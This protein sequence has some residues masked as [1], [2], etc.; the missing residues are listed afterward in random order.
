MKKH[1]FECLPPVLEPDILW[2]HHPKYPLWVSNNG[3]IY[4][5]VEDPGYLTRN[6]YWISGRKE[7]FVYEACFNVVLKKGT[8]I[9]QKDGNPYNLH[10]DNLILYTDP[11]DL[12]KARKREKMFMERTMLEMDFKLKG[13]PKNIPYMYYFQLIGVPAKFLRSYYN[14]KENKNLTISEFL[15]ISYTKIELG[16]LGDFSKF[17]D[18]LPE[19][20]IK[21]I[22]TKKELVLNES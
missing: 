7:K 18:G 4:D 12:R 22:R 8:K 13:I 20:G 6:Y 21:R 16:I 11:K 5:S 19:E 9:Y 3:F 14:Y 17:K 1:L 2:Y 10:M 15:R